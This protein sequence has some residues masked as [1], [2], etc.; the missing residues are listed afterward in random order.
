[1]WLLGVVVLQWLALIAVLLF[2]TPTL[3][4][5][6]EHEDSEHV[7]AFKQFVD[8]PPTIKSLKA[9]RITKGRTLVA[10][11]FGPNGTDA[12]VTNA[13]EKVFM[14]VRYQTNGLFMK[15]ATSYTN[16][17]RE[18][19]ESGCLA[20]GWNW[21]EKAAWGITE[22][23]ILIHKTANNWPFAEGIGSTLKLANT[24]LRMGL[25][26]PSIKPLRW[27]GYKVQGTNSHGK[28]FMGELQVDTQGRPSGMDYI[29]PNGVGTDT[30]RLAIHIGYFYEKNISGWDLPTRIQMGSTEFEVLSAEVTRGLLDRW[31]FHS[32]PLLNPNRSVLSIANVRNGKN[33]VQRYDDQK[34]GHALVAGFWIP[35]PR[36]RIFFFVIVFVFTIAAI[37][38]GY[39]VSRKVKNN[40]QNK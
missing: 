15:T 2:T 38:F 32:A 30:N 29:Y 39:V 3:A 18:S 19:L 34:Y 25:T 9:I 26:W 1:M 12:V 28:V 6:S 21:D 11:G 13:G 8:S 22:S 31:R 14:E 33:V 17:L 27:E 23:G 24:L 16:L 4:L 40:N 20:A 5:D 7:R 35:K 10:E 37:T 36:I